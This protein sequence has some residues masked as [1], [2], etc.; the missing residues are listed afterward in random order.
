MKVLYSCLSKS[1]GG[2][3]MFTIT[4]VKEL[5][6]RDI[7]TELA[8]IKDSPIHHEAIKNDIKTISIKSFNYFNP[9]QIIK[10]FKI[11]KHM[12]YSLIHT[13]YSKDL[14]LLVPALKIAK[15]KIPLFLTK[16]MGSFIIKKDYLHKKLYKRVTKI[17]AISNVIKKNLIETCPVDEDKIII[18]HNAV[19]TKKFSPENGHRGKIRKEFQIAENEIVIGMLARFTPGKGHEEFLFAA[20]ELNKK[21]DNLKFMIVG[22]PSRD[23]D[24]Y[25]LKIKKL[26]GTYKL[27]DKIIFTGFRT[28]TVD[29][30]S[31]MDIFAFPSHSEAFGIALVEA[32]SMSL[33]SVC[34]NSD[35]ILD[36]A[37][38]GETSL[39]FEN[40]NAF[41]LKEK[42]EI[43][44]QKQDMRKELGYNARQRA[45]QYFDLK[46]LS[47]K[48]IEYYKKFH[49]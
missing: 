13:Q 6:N 40:R 43:L 45:I 42:L 38:N 7:E 16:Q 3:E 48:V 20:S 1:W 46:F 14:W 49:N 37:I 28:D 31:S 30:L 27:G 26:A 8:C 17:F 9:I 2:M 18:L 24:N 32:M 19:D 39:L 23:E 33:P 29:I 35:G 10:F 44:I 47:D 22:D 41:D 21:Y 12:N 34:S 5:L 25:G 36:I 11:I 15:S 4:A